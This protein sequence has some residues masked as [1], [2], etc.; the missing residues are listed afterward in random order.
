M[1]RDTNRL[2]DPFDATDLR[3]RDVVSNRVPADAAPIDPTLAELEKAST[4]IIDPSTPK[5]LDPSTPKFDPDTATPSGVDAS[6]P[7]LHDAV[8]S[9]PATAGVIDAEPASEWW[10]D[11]FGDGV[12][13][14]TTPS[15][16]V[17]DLD[18]DG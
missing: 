16:P 14:D 5:V 12:V 1:S 8:G 11:M 4:K 2:N 9:D 3:A 7:F 6:S 10:N 15:G 18:L 13:D 17:D